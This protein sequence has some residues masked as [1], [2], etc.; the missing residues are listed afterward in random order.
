MEG[1]F[2]LSLIFSSFLV[3]IIV[4]ISQRR[5]YKKSSYYKITKNP[6]SSVKYDKGRYGEYLTY[7]NLKR[8][9]R[10]GGKFLFNV[11]IPKGNNGTSEIDA[12]LIC[13]KGLFIFESKNYSGWIFGHEMQRNWTQTLPIGRGRSHKEY[14][15]N[16]IMQNASHIRHLKRIIDRN[17]PMRSIVVFSER[18][19]L[20][21]ITIRS[22]NVSVIKRN[23]V[24][25]VVTKICSQMP[26]DV[27]TQ[28]E[29]N[30]IFNKL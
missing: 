2:S 7:K 21:D 26:D 15:Y 29:I 19:V 20:K 25:S 23:N 12:M 4:V 1:F 11:Y 27:L 9:E 18:C 30:N 16:P 8:F 24:L 6:Y 13:S 14:F 17:V 3:P 5:Q 10:N 28:I 22:D